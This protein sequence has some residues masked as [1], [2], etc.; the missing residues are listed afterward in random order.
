MKKFGILTIFIFTCFI[1]VGQ[2]IIPINIKRTES[3]GIWQYDNLVLDTLS[4]QL[5]VNFIATDTAS[6]WSTYSDKLRIADRIYECIHDDLPLIPYDSICFPGDTLRFTETFLPVLD[7]Q[8]S[9]KGLSL[10]DEDTINFKLTLPSIDWNQDT[11]ALQ[12]FLFEN[13]RKRYA[14]GDYAASSRNLRLAVEMDSSFDVS[15]VKDLARSIYSNIRTLHINSKRIIVNDLYTLAHKNISCFDCD[16]MNYDLYINALNQSDFIDVQLDFSYPDSLCYKNKMGTEAVSVLDYFLKENEYGEIDIIRIYEK[17]LNY[18]SY[19]QEYDQALN[20]VR[21]LEKVI[22]NYRNKS[23]PS[24][25]NALVRE[26]QV[27]NKLDSIESAV[28]CCEKALEIFKNSDVH[29]DGREDN[30]P[31]EEHCHYLLS[32]FYSRLQNASLAMYHNKN[33]EILHQRCKDDSELSLAEILTQRGSIYRD[34]GRY[35]DM[36]DS[37]NNAL[38]L[39]QNDTCNIN[40]VKP[41]ELLK[42]ISD[43]LIYLEKYKEARKFVKLELEL[44]RLEDNSIKISDALSKLNYIAIAFNDSLN[45]FSSMSQIKELYDKGLIQWDNYYEVCVRMFDFSVD[46]KNFN[47]AKK[48]IETLEPIITNLESEEYAYIQ[49]ARS[50]LYFYTGEIAKAIALQEAEMQRRIPIWGNNSSLYANCLNNLSVYYEEIGMLDEAVKYGEQSY[51]L[52]DSILDDSD[53]VF[54]HSMNNLSSLYLKIGD[55]DKSKKLLE[56]HLKISMNPENGITRDKGEIMQHL[57]LIYMDLDSLSIAKKYLQEGLDLIKIAYS[58]RS[59]EYARALSVY[60]DYYYKIDDYNTAF[61]LEKQSLDILKNIVGKDSQYY[62]S[63]LGYG[64]Y[65]ASLLKDW[66]WMKS[67]FEIFNN[68]MIK[69]SRDNLLNINNSYMEDYWRTQQEWFFNLLPYYAFNNPENQEIVCQAYNGQLYA[70][71]LLLNIRRHSNVEKRNIQDKLLVNESNNINNE[72]LELKRKRVII[73]WKKIRESL[74]SESIAIEFCKFEDGDSIQYMALVVEPESEY[75]VVVKLFEEQGVLNINPKHQYSTKQLAEL[76]WKP[77][78]SILRKY[79]IVYFSP[80]GILHTIAIESLPDYEGKGNISDRI[81]FHRLT[82]TRELYNRGDLNDSKSAVAFGGIDYTAIKISGNRKNIERELLNVTRSSMCPL[83]ATKIEIESIKN[84]LCESKYDV[85]IYSGADATEIEFKGL[86]Y[87]NPKYVHVATHGFYWEEKE[88]LNKPQRHLVERYNKNTTSKEEIALC[89]SGL[90][91][92]GARKALS[93][94]DEDLYLSN[95]GIL[96]AK[97]ISNMNLSGVDMIVLSAC[98]TGLGEISD[99][100]VLGLQR[101]FK[102]AGVKSIMMSLWEVDDEATQKLMTEFYRNLANGNTK[103]QSL[104]L[105]Q[106][107]VRATPGFEDPEYWAAFILLDALN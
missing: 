21:E 8:N 42:Y 37:W 9:G 18:L 88:R 26:S 105:A 23:H 40:I 80:I 22:Y 77:L 53:P 20:K 11:I 74:S 61:Q 34:T 66:D 33:T 65:Y 56:R 31:F 97:E 60:G 94:Y 85:K 81:I 39:I 29:I 47:D 52:R 13:A 64:L 91:F 73:N 100:G 14:E 98:Q 63:K 7:R 57:G 89:R 5:Q 1:I 43:V 93:G 6:I 27:L 46:I 50:K 67:K 107:K 104:K 106:L 28:L 24:Y 45:A 55:Y 12:R 87:R 54:H 35:E 15:V 51:I 95:D 4:T 96:T 38:R 102:I 19:C 76:I 3:Y 30:L 78:D 16:L 44:G 83:P 86:S 75:P 72:D 10:E 17:Q 90:L 69:I 92:A 99:D 59:M 2:I 58:E 32:H 49:N 68:Y 62:I 103:E 71:A 41:Y 25:A 36:I 82:S 79:K 101:G 84:T 48:I 70:K